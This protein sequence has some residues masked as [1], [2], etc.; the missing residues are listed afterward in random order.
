MN[1]MLAMIDA[2]DAKRKALQVLADNRAAK[3]IHE[4]QSWIRPF[5]AHD[6]GYW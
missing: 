2:R 1:I 5:P 6:T 3:N 4:Q